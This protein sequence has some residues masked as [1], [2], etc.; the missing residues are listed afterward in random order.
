MSHKEALMASLLAKPKK[1][2]F[3]IAEMTSRQ[4]TPEILKAAKPDGFPLPHGSTY[5]DL[6]SL[7]TDVIKRCSVE[8][9]PLTQAARFIQ[10]IADQFNGSPT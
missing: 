6:E 5:A 7:T 9:Y 3:D 4:V 8:G 1:V 2:T 10:Q